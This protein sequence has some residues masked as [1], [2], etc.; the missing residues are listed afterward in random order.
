MKN[1]TIRILSGQD[2][3]KVLSMSEC[4]DTMETTFSLLGKGNITLP[5]RTVVPMP[6]ERGNAL[7]MPSYLPHINKVGIKALNVHKHNGEKGLPTN[8]AMLMLFDSVTGSPLALMNGNV[9]TAMRTGAI[10]GLA[11]KYLA[12]KNSKV[13][14]LI[15]PGV[16]GETQLEA[17]AAVRDIEKVFVYGS[18]LEK[19]EAYAQKMSTKLNIEIIPSTNYDNISQADIVCTA[20]PSITPLFND[21]LISKGTHINAVGSYTYE[22]NEI[23]IDT[24]L[25]SKIVVDEMEAA[26]SEA[27]ELMQAIANNLMTKEDIFAEIG[28]VVSGIK[29][30]RESEEEITFFKSV[31]VSIQDLASANLVLNKAQELGIGTEVEI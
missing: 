29:P 27:G 18:S 10:S 20:T 6:E 13:V 2:V 15:G 3:S 4:I 1:N 17:V 21:N 25:R 5:H 14:A 19:A 28:Q 7:F 16:Q 9:L 26:L 24:I 23:P 8:Q 11:T 30:A 31:G 12:R 22:M